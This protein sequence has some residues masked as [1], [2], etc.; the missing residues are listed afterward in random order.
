M[1]LSTEEI[2]PEA[3]ESATQCENRPDTSSENMGKEI[4]NQQ[5]WKTK[6]SKL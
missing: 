4:Q 2:I 6:T 3:D 5:Q 1:N